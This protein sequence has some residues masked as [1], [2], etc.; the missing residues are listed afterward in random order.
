MITGP[1]KIVSPQV[2]LLG[3]FPSPE[4]AGSTFPSPESARSTFPSPESAGSTFPEPDAVRARLVAAGGVY[5]GPR[6]F[7]ATVF[8]AVAEDA[9]VFLDA[10][11]GLDEA[12]ST[13]C[14]MVTT[15]FSNLILYSI[16]MRSFSFT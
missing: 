6:S 1:N 5:I 15:F 14:V 3:E 16:N 7:D 13:R 11:T 4:S 9:R 8:A 12:G 2:P 10:A